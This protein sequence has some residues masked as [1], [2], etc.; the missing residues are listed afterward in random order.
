MKRLL[1]ISLDTLL[2]S[3]LPIVMWILLGFIITKEISNVF[4]LTYPLQ[5]FYM[6][7][8]SLFA[9]GPNITAKRLKN[10]NVIYSNM[11]FGCIC[12]GILTLILVLCSD[13]YINI[14]SMDINIYHNFCI[15]SMIWMYFSFIMQVITQKLYYETKNKESN[16]INLVFNNY[17]NNFS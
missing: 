13:T 15:Y 2:T 3:V 12:V 1:Q 16:K 9:V 10:E 14:M 6:I 4:T 7:F 11:L 8:I 17:F 5:F